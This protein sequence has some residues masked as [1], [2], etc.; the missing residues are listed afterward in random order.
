PRAAPSSV[1][2]W[3]GTRVRETIQSKEIGMSGSLPPKTLEETLKVLEGCGHANVRERNAKNGAPDNQFGMNMGDIRAIAKSIKTHH[4]LGLDLWGSGNLDAMLLAT[5]IMVP[6]RISEEELE[7][8]TASV[9]YT[10][11]ADWLMTNI[12]KQ[13]PSKESMRQR[14]M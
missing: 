4:E 12:V 6:K 14:W 11:L 1:S 5:L 13:H 3:Q 9:T 7:R 8:M 2:A 10:W